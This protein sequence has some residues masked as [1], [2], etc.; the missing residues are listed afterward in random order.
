MLVIWT[1]SMLTQFLL[2]QIQTLV[3]S[4]KTI[5]IGQTSGVRHHLLSGIVTKVL[6]RVGTQD[7]EEIMAQAMVSLDLDCLCSLWKASRYFIGKW[8]F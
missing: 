1:I 4:I 7:Q 3:I 2:L 8:S 6:P 5:V